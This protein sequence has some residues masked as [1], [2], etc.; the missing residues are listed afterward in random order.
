LEGALTEAGKWWEDATEAVA[1][2]DRAGVLA[3]V[4]LAVEALA[5]ALQHALFVTFA[6]D[7]RKGHV[8]ES[9]GID[10]YCAG[11]GLTTDD[12]NQLWSWLLEDPLEFG[13]KEL[14]IA[15]DT[16]NRCAY[17]KTESGW[18][19]FLT[20]ITPVWGAAV[21]YGVIALL[22]ALL[23]AAELTTWPVNWGWKM[24]VLLLFVALGALAHIATSALSVNYDDPMKVYDAGGLLDWLSLRWIAVMRMYVPVMFVVASLWGAGN[25]PTSFQDLGTAL[26]AGYSADSAIRAALSKLNATPAT[27]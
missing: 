2:S 25:V 26:L 4:E 10:A 21:V 23:H 6:D 13:G 9:R 19:R 8:G 5:A 12:V 27:A 1:S 14:P 15:L 3:N 18:L 20:A 16:V 22:F 7:V 11:W 24:L 17:R